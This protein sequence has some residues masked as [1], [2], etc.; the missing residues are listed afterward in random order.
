M[1]RLERE[2]LTNERRH[3]VRF[4]AGPLNQKV[5][6]TLCLPTTG[7]YALEQLQI[8]RDGLKKLG[9]HSRNTFGGI[10]KRLR[11]IF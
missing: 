4:H 7:R 11:I 2:R 9:P 8:G 3:S 6:Y 10:R 5:V 1:I